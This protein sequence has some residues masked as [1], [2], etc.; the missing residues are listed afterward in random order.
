M[1]HA[2]KFRRSL[3]AA[4][5]I[6]IAIMSLAFY[7]A[8]RSAGQAEGMN[9][10]VARTQEVLGVIARARLERARLQNRVWAYRAT[11]NPDLPGRFQSDLRGL[12]EDME[13][14]QVLTDDSPAQRKL[15]AELAPLITAQILS[16]ERAMQRAI[17]AGAANSNPAFDWSLP[18]PP[19][20]RVRLLFDG[21][22]SNESVLLATRTEAVQ[23]NARKTRGVLLIA[24]VLTFAILLA[25]GHLVQ[26]EILMRAK[27]ESGMRVAQ[28][29]LGLEYEEQ[30]YKLGHA[31]EDLHAQIR[32]R[33]LA[34]NAV[35]QLNGDLER[36]VHQHTIELEEMNRELEAFSYSVS[37]DL[38]AP[39]RHLDG[40]SRILQQEYG[41]KLPDE[42]RHYLDRIRNAATHM[43]DLV[44]DLLQLSRLGRQPAHRELHSLRTLVDEARAEALEG[45]DGRKIVWQIYS[46][47]EVHADAALLRQV[48]TNLFSNAVKFTRQQHA[49]VI[50]VGS[51]EENGMNVIFVRDNG[52]G[53]DPRYADKLFGVFQR[54]HRQDE[55]EGTGIGLATAQR[56]IQK[57]GG[58]VWAESQPGQGATFYFS[59]PM[60]PQGSQEVQETAGALG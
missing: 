49:A 18:S 17:S 6:V 29:M 48:L 3:R 43:S 39:L 38:R 53:F 9:R 41:P 46:L 4:S 5:A 16:L 51:T 2:L 35:H 57:H 20:D 1:N 10:W 26:R 14:L 60:S 56:I 25:A 21:L 8:F 30:R 42:A 28:E 59:L 12:R 58:R 7:L 37:H 45:S 32:A 34:E 40:F 13:R 50:E 33:R 15:L 27:V 22:E 11:H 54:L 55:F 31:V 19:S 36:R 52:A 44:E 23:A 24:G 47:P